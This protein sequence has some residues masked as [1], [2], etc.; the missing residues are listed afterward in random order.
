MKYLFGD[1]TPS[2]LTHNFIDLLR[3]AI[4][5]SVA[6]LLADERIASCHAE[7]ARETAASED[8]IQELHAMAAALAHCI[9]TTPKGDAASA[10]AE[11]A[12]SIVRFIA[13]TVRVQEAAVERALDARIRTLEAKEGAEREG[14]LVS[15]GELL[16]HHDPPGA[17]TTLRLVLQP[18]G[19]YVATLNGTTPYGL[20][21]E[22]LLDIPD[23]HPFAHAV[24]VDKLTAHVDVQAPESAGWLRKEVKLRAQ[25]LDRYFVSELTVGN[26]RARIALRSEDS[27]RGAG[28]DVTVGSDVPRVGFSRVGDPGGAP[29]TPFALGAEDAA[30][31]LALSDAITSATVDLLRPSSSKRVRKMLRKAAL[32]G[33]SFR[34]HPR[35]AI[36]VDRLVAAMGPTTREIDHHSLGSHELVLKRLLSGDRREEIFVP[37]SALLDSIAR[38]SDAARERFAPLGL[39]ATTNGSG[40]IP[41]GLEARPSRESP[42]SSRA[43]VELGPPPPVL[44]MPAAGPESEPESAFESERESKAQRANDTNGDEFASIEVLPGELVFPTEEPSVII[45]EGVPDR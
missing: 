5:T 19:I 24:R 13:E 27:G 37:K 4:E 8:E 7:I 2:T 40:H 30:K 23:T 16:L 28:F 26:A 45:D 18:G 43:T 41:A 20:D 44:S 32:D 25:K 1:A 9:D 42:P 6:L 17:S 10:T 11:G 3:D 38:L 39:N 36:V 12:I 14:C 33:I 22:L 35:L 34:D 31:L 29:D 21:Y 15:L